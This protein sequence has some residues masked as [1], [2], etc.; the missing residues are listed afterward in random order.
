MTDTIIMDV[1]RLVGRVYDGMLPTGVDRI[2]LAYMQHYRSKARALIIYGGRWM[3]FSPALS[4]YL[5]DAIMNGK[6]HFRWL[7]RAFV[8]W[9]YLF[10]WYR[11]KA[12]LMNIGQVGLEKKEYGTQARKRGWRCVFFLHDLIPITHSEYFAIGG[13]TK[14]H[15][16]V[17]T[18]LQH[19][20]KLIIN[21]ADTLHHLRR[22]QEKERLTLPPC[23]VA[24]PAPATLLETTNPPP[25]SHP[26][27]VILSTIEPRKNHLLL[28]HIWREMVENLAD[29]APRLVIIGQRGWECEQVVDL[30]ER[31]AG[32]R[33]VVTEIPRCGD[34][35]L[36]VWLK[37]ARALLF[38]TFAEGFGIPLVEA[39]AM[40]VP[41]IVS[42]IPVFRE[43]AE[44]IPEYLDPIDG[45]GWKK[46]ILEYMDPVSALR[47]AQLRR[48]QDYS[49]PTWEAHFAVVD[50]FLKAKSY[51]HHSVRSCDGFA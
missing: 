19:A 23:V 7:A 18:M 51:T 28:L 36:A 22:Y 41:V 32:L 17:R 50:A 12:W 44:D 11:G 15:Q 31:C 37:H 6:P 5:F 4:Q 21:S 24:F 10:G 14:H 39:L 45:L 27:F 30:L 9:G 35:E 3:V 48:M 13:T 16:R 46:T 26:Y 47:Q 38:P 40:R 43:I 29:A 42:D 20:A 8:V 49:P 33:G 1:S 25:I 2:M 34:E